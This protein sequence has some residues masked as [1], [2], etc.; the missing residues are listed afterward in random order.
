MWPRPIDT[1]RSRA[2]RCSA[3]RGL[4][5][6]WASILDGEAANAR[7]RCGHGPAVGARYPYLSPTSHAQAVSLLSAGTV[8]IF[9]RVAEPHARFCQG[10]FSR[11]RRHGKQGANGRRGRPR[12]KPAPPS[13]RGAHL[14]AP[15]G[16]LRKA[17]LPMPGLCCRS[18]GAAL[19]AGLS[20]C[21]RAQR[22]QQG[23]AV[24]RRSAARL[25]QGLP[26]AWPAARGRILR[27]SLSN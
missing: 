15:S 8:A 13:G 2:A 5:K 27:S 22:L 7:I 25:Q 6:Q 4:L 14:W 17:L 12:A 9:L 24:T 10:I 26:A 19:A 16:S 11:G 21:S 20:A 23:A 1:A 3:R 18:R